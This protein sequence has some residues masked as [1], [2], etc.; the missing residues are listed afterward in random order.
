MNY[1]AQEMKDAFNAFKVADA[2]H[3]AHLASEIAVMKQNQANAQRFLV[4]IDLKTWP[5]SP[6][7]VG[8]SDQEKHELMAW[9][10]KYAAAMKLYREEAYKLQEK[11]TAALNAALYLLGE[12]AGRAFVM[13]LGPF[14]D[15]I[16]LVLAQ[17]DNIRYQQLD[18]FG[19]VNVREEDDSFA[20]GFYQTT[21]LKKSQLFADMA[22]CSQYRQQWKQVAPAE[23]ERLGFVEEAAYAGR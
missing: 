16:A 8:M 6:C 5:E 17:A 12:H 9:G 20:K 1:I 19:Y 13:A 2:A 15:R 4:Y 3:A 22:L 11:R 21:G 23:L 10:D 7:T 14:D 18:G